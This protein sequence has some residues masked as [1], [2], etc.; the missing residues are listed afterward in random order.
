MVA[1]VMILEDAW[2]YID[3]SP[4]VLHIRDIRA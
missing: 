4:N 3:V 2:K 1:T